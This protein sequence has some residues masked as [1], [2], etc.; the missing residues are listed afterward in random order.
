[1]GI[2]NAFEFG[3]GALHMTDM[4][5]LSRTC[6]YIRQCVQKSTWYWTQ[7]VQN[8]V[9]RHVLRGRPMQMAYMSSCLSL[10]N[11]NAQ[12]EGYTTT[13]AYVQEAV[14]CKRLR[15]WYKKLY[16]RKTKQYR[17]S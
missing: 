14:G 10:L 3:R 4:L 1:M 2:L 12:R 16:I 11:A 8:S 5:T 17:R 7:A 6:V 9:H 15:R 13:Q